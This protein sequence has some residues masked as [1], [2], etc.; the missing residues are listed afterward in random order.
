MWTKIKDWY[1]YNIGDYEIDMRVMWIVI[2]AVK[3]QIDLEMAKVMQEMYPRIITDVRQ[4]GKEIYFNILF[5]E[6]RPVAQEFLINAN[7]RV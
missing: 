6:N 3:N 7:A 4:D 1:Y 2:N 5:K